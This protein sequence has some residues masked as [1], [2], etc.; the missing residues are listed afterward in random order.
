M[1][2]PFHDTRQQLVGDRLLRRAEC[3][4]M[5]VDPLDELDVRRLLEQCRVW[6]DSKDALYVAT[7]VRDEHDG[8]HRELF[9]IADRELRAGLRATVA[10]W[11]DQED[12]Q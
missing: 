10:R 3:E 1:I 7:H 5:G 8:D 6:I 11:D 4:L 12:E 9:G 2:D